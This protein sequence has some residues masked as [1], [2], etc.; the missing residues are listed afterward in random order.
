MNSPRRGSGGDAQPGVLSA[1][2]GVGYQSC[3]SPTNGA[4]AIVVTDGDAG[5]AQARADRLA[6]EL[7]RRREEWIYEV[8]SPSDALRDGE[9]SPGRPKAILTPPCALQ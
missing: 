2:V 5:D 9:A 8:P 1:S 4:C 6:V 3:D 7:W